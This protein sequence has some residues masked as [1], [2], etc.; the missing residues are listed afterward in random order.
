M[1]YMAICHAEDPAAP[2]SKYRVI[3]DY[4]GLPYQGIIPISEFRFSSSMLYCSSVVAPPFTLLVFASVAS[5][6]PKTALCIDQS[7][8][9]G[10]LV[11]TA[12]VL[13]DR[14]PHPVVPCSTL[15]YSAVPWYV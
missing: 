14:L 9:P 15:Q 4:T 10:P 7:V 2:G 11:V 8:V 1:I 6:I 13:R 12:A 5:A 3:G